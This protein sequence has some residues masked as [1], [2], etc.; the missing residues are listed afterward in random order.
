[1][2]HHGLSF[3]YGHCLITILMLHYYWVTIHLHFFDYCPSLISMPTHRMH[4]STRIV[5]FS[6]CICLRSLIIKRLPLHSTD[7]LGWDT[8]VIEAGIYR[9]CLL[10][11]TWVTRFDWLHQGR[12]CQMPHQYL[13]DKYDLGTQWMVICVDT[14]LAIK[15]S[16]SIYHLHMANPL[17]PWIWL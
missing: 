16:L 9:I 6:L 13:D 4:I 14:T 17:D 7:L 8:I 11:R 10:D 1:M 15:L 12:H 5:W 3:M 2:F